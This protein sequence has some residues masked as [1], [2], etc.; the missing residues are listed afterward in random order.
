MNEKQTEETLPCFYSPSLLLSSRASSS[1]KIIQRQEE[2]C[3]APNSKCSRLTQRQTTVCKPSSITGKH[4]VIGTRASPRPR[5]G[6]GCFYSQIN[7]T[8][9]LSGGLS[10]SVRVLRWFSNGDGWGIDHLLS[11]LR[12][13]ER[14][15]PADPPP[16]TNWRAPPSWRTA[17]AAYWR[18][19]AAERAHS[20]LPPTPPTPPL[21][22]H[23]PETG[24]TK[25]RFLKKMEMFHRPARG[26]ATESVG[27]CCAPTCAK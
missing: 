12:L 22:P 2:V 26:S 16:A 24:R 23:G 21:S 11:A 6:S 13:Y 3:R 27:L 14:R 15:T 1:S 18:A 8:H 25:E 19:E 5:C 4:A 17:R 10:L 7:Q 20:H 9:L